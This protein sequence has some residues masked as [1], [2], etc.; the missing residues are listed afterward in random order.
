MTVLK[1]PSAT[2][3]ALETGVIYC[4]D[5][6]EVMR[7]LPSESIDT[8]YV[9]P[10]FF[11]GKKYETIWGDT[12]ELAY[13]DYRKGGIEFF[14]EEWMAPRLDQMHRLLK[15][16]GSLFLHMDGNAFHYVKVKLDYVFGG[17][18]PNLGRDHFVNDIVWYY[19]QGGGKVKDKFAE[20]HDNILWYAKDPKRYKVFL[21]KVRLPYTPHKGSASGRNYG[22][23]M[24]VDEDGREYVEKW[25]TGK[26]KLYR[27]YLD[28]GKTPEDVWVDIQSIQSA[29]KERTGWDTQKPLKLLERIISLSTKEDDVVGDFFCGCGTTLVAAHALGRKYV[30]CDISSK[31]SVIVRKRLEDI[32][33]D[34]KEI[35]LF[36]L[37]R[38][39]VMRLSD[40]EFQDYMV[41]CV[42]GE[43]STRRTN[44]H[45]IDGKLIADGTPI[46]VKKSKSIDRPTI[47]KY[48]KHLKSNGRFVFIALSFGRGAYE[49][50]ARQKKDGYDLKLLTM[51]EVLRE[52][53][54][55][56]D[57][58]ADLPKVT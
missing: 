18:N 39:E 9:D 40:A 45:G 16:T 4:A 7:Q 21:D 5:N 8:I 57:P 42:G 3:Q 11:S 35:T 37:S 47:D 58:E 23:K 48:L 50:Q 52:S 55:R 29:A 30:G 36:N 51:D 14:I 6:L 27:Y 54:H 24:G 20:R 1:F 10:P 2:K 53:F 22:G 56:L 13:R 38:S 46:Q 33:E 17:G 41:R 32:G 26:K 31:A 25:G 12:V 49:E 34:C 44:D 28:E 43:P 15:P 19:S